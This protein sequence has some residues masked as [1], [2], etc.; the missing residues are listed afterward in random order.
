MQSTASEQL[1]ERQKMCSLLNQTPFEL[2]C[3]WD[4][5]LFSHLHFFYVVFKNAEKKKK[6]VY[7]PVYPHIF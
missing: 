7:D 1:K 6:Q 3:S 4:F 5:I 2:L